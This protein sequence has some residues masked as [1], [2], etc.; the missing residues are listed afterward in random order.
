M[1]VAAGRRAW[2]LLGPSSPRRERARR[3][4]YV[5]LCN[6]NSGRTGLSIH[7]RTVTARLSAMEAQSLSRTSAK[8]SWAPLIHAPIYSSEW[9]MASAPK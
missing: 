4:R 9:T 2:S 5:S 3:S 1:T 7:R 6:P 8:N